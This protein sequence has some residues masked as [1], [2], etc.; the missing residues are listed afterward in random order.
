MADGVGDEFGRSED[1]N[2]QLVVQAVDELTGT[3]TIG[4]DTWNQ[5]RNTFTER[6][7]MDL[8]FTIGGYLL[9]ALVV[10]TFGVQDEEQQ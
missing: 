6:Q 7:C 10:N 1:H 3:C 9:L 4:Q 8:T 5:L 2:D